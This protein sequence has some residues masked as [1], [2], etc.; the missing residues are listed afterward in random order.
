MGLVCSGI[1]RAA[2]AT[3]HHPINRSLC[4]TLYC[5]A[6]L[7]DPG[8]YCT[9]CGGNGDLLWVKVF[10]LKVLATSF[11]AAHGCGSS[12]A[13]AYL[14]GNSL[15]Y[16]NRRGR[17]ESTAKAASEC[18]NRV[19]FAVGRSLGCV[20]EAKGFEGGFLGVFSGQ[21]TSNESCGASCERARHWNDASGCCTERSG[22]RSSKSGNDGV[23]CF[24]N[25]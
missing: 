25:R 19:S 12:G 13:L 16:A 20:V 18:R 9:G 15:T 3:G 2:G 21:T 7:V 8:E 24:S 5:L 11:E 4:W 17:N 22:S 14:L 23:G 6:E 10:S 1:G